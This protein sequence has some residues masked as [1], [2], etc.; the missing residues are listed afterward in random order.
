[1]IKTENEAINALENL[2]NILYALEQTKEINIFNAVGMSKQE[3]K[4]SSFL[5]WLFAPQQ[6]HGKGNLFLCDFLKALYYYP[7]NDNIEVFSNSNILSATFTYEEIIDIATASDIKVE[8]EK[9]IDNPD[10]RIDIFIYSK[11]KNS[12]IVIENKVFTSTHDD[13]LK[14][15]ELEVE[16]LNTDKTLKKIFIYLTPFGETPTDINGE[17]QQGWCIIDYATIVN[18]LKKRIGNI[19]NQKLKYLIEDYINMVD[20]K[21]LHN[22]P[23]IRSLCKKI[24]KEH[25]EAIEILLNYIDNVDMAY[26]YIANTWLPQNI[27]NC[28]Y[29][30][31][32]GRKLVFYTDA[33]KN[34]Y[35]KHGQEMEISDGLFKFQIS[36]M[37][38]DGPV[39]MDMWLSKAEEDKWTAA[40]I[41]IHDILQPNKKMGK[42]YCTLF[43]CPILSVEEREKVFENDKDLYDLID[44]RLRNFLSKLSELEK[45]LAEI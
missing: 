3:V 11:E 32:N 26:K 21:I 31:A 2:S 23:T 4:H 29:V 25:Q 34:F 39:S 28:S 8:T 12:V 13:Q 5:S 10:S 27:Q 14:R 19:R 42:K 41:K 17:Y 44:D 9:V 22:N 38:K 16:K 6:I 1:M 36:V 24:R 45:K 33:I 43:S 37:S 30:N 20:N 15:Y 18:N 40:D 7:Q 35:N